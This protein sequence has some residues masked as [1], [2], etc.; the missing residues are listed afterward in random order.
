LFASQSYKGKVVLVTGASRGIG[1]ETAIQ[2]A[3]AGASIVLVARTEESLT[4]TTDLIVSAAPGAEVLALAADVREAKAAEAAV[5][6]VL[7]RFGKLDVLIANAGSISVL[8]KRE[9]GLDFLCS[10]KMID[11]VSPSVLD[12]KDPDAWWKAFEVN[13]R[14]TFNFVWCGRT[15][16]EMFS[17]ALP[18]SNVSLLPLPALPYVPS[19]RH[20]VTSSHSLP[21]GRSFGF[22]E[23]AMRTSRSM[24]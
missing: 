14:G 16:A 24:P 1:Q 22:R 17:S 8:G 20:A 10:C 9:K 11:L 15:A 2:Y 5:Q 23:A 13:I 7:E 21:S 19:R 6:R 12:E 18:Q 4:G 3:R